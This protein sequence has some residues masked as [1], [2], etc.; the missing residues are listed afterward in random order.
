ME[1]TSTICPRDYAEPSHL[2]GLMAVDRT[3]PKDVDR[4][5]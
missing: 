5:A 1:P 2:S 4:H 3:C